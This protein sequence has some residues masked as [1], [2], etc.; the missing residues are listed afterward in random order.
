VF[1][2]SAAILCGLLFS[3][4][5]DP[6]SRLGQVL[7]RSVA[8]VA[9]TMAVAVAA[10]TGF[11][12]AAHLGHEIRD[13]DIGAFRSIF[14]ASEL[15][16]EA[17]DR[18]ARWTVAPPLTRPAAVSREDQYASEGLLHVQ[19]RNEQRDAGH[20]RAAWSENLILET[21]FAPVL[22][23]PSYVSTTGHRWTAEHRAEAMRRAGAPPSSGSDFASRAHGEFPILLWPKATFLS[24]AAAVVAALLGLAFLARRK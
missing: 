8:Y 6:P 10:L 24:V 17:A 9:T 21:Y 2:N 14:S 3:V 23:T 1:L 4:A 13:P 16:A 12:G 22:D 5:V 15:R 19:E 11:L 18:A 20:A 7:S